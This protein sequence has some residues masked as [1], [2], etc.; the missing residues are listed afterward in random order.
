M[1]IILTLRIGRR[2]PKPKMKKRDEECNFTTS[3]YLSRRQVNGLDALVE[4]EIFPSRTE[5][6]RIAIDDLL[7]KLKQKH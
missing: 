6:I 7:A 4:D 3:I 5:A 1:E 2:K